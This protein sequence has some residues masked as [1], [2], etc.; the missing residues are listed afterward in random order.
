MTTAHRP[1]WAPAKGNDEQG[2]ARL[3]GS[4]RAVSGK[5]LNSHTTLKERCERTTTVR[6][7]TRC[8]SRM[9]A[10]VVRLARI[11]SK[12]F[13]PICEGWSWNN[14]LPPSPPGH[15]HEI[16]VPLYSGDFERRVHAEPSCEFMKISFRLRR[17]DGQASARDLQKR[18]LKLEL[19]EKER[20]HFTSKKCALE[21]EEE[22]LPARLESRAGAFFFFPPLT[23]P[24]RCPSLLAC[25]GG[26]GAGDPGRLALDANKKEPVL[27]PKARVARQGHRRG[28]ALEK[29]RTAITSSLFPFAAAGHRRRRL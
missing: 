6:G 20:K 7:G 26:V 8:A 24:A 12:Q 11:V 25:R 1:T 2:G 13:F 16:R 22:L 23:L 29:S 14:L 19:E 4:S 15:L 27:V 9:H 17:K 5:N 10:A 18:D 28:S 3:F 21:R